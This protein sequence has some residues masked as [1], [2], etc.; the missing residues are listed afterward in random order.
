MVA[1]YTRISM[2]LGDPSH[3]T[4][5]FKANY[6]HVPQGWFKV[7]IISILQEGCTGIRALRDQIRKILGY[8]YM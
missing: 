3:P 7:D 5:P 8:L 4:E 1:C 6:L 2:E